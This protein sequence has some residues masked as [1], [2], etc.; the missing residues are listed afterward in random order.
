MNIRCEDVHYAYEG[1][2]RPAIRGLSLELA[3]GE[4]VALVGPSGAGKSTLA[5]LLLRFIE[6]QRGS[7]TIAG[8]PLGSMTAAAWRRQVAWVPQNPYLF[9][10]TVADNIRLSRPE[11]TMAQ[12]EEAAQLAHIHAFVA[13]LPEG[14]GTIVGERGTR[15]SGGEAQRVALAR[16]FLKDAP[17]L[18]LDEATANLDPENEALL[19][20]A[21]DQLLK[22]RTALV[23]AHRLGTI[24]RA[25]RI[26][27]MEEGR[28]VEKG[29]HASL[30]QE[31]GLYRRLVGAYGGGGAR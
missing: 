20:E 18:I 2:E 7:I 19:T 11:V 30:I 12:I 21:M 14:Y 1:D 22:G 27:V 25:N 8:Q 6:P 13:A 29:T 4:T 16:A 15:L 9:H 5:Y 17:L 10:G 24:Y 28:I 3:A 23:I 26:L 31:G